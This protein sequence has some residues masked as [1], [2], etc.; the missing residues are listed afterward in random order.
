MPCAYISVTIP[1]AYCFFYQFIVHLKLYV[2]LKRI[3]AYNKIIVKVWTMKKRTTDHLQ[4]ELMDSPDLARFL[5]KNENLFVNKSIAELLNQLFEK[6]NISKAALA[7]QSGMSEIYLHQI[8]CRPQK[9]LQ[10]P[11]FMPV[12]RSGCKHRGSPGAVEAVRHGSAL[13]KAETRCYHL[14]WAATWSWAF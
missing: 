8:F 3:V 11:S 2:L 13:S 7:K 10:E 1:C 5:T 6:K 14:L 9:S 4:Q 12:L